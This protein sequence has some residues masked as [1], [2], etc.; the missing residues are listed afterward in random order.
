VWKKKCFATTNAPERM[1]S[2]VRDY[3][4]N[5][6][7]KELLTNTASDNIFVWM[8]STSNGKI[9][10]FELEDWKAAMTCYNAGAS[11]YFR[12]YLLILLVLKTI[13][14]PKKCRRYL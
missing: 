14:H 11:L 12:Y 5:L 4:F 8:K 10:S 2:I 9:D 3:L 6:D 13:D 1:N 7:L